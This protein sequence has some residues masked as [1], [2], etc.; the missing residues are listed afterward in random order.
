VYA[1]TLGGR[2]VVAKRRT[3]GAEVEHEAGILQLLD[4]KHV[5]HVPQ[6][7]G[8]VAGFLVLQPQ[9]RPLIF[10]LPEKI[11]LNVL[12]D[13]SEALVRAAESGVIHRDVSL[14]NIIVHECRG[15]LIDW[16]AACV[17]SAAKENVPPYGTIAYASRR[18]IRAIADG[19]GRFIGDVWVR[20]RQS[21][22]AFYV[23]TPCLAGRP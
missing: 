20:A 22:C 16:H 21:I 6:L 10:S 1:A 13:A 19:D 2:S 23:L 15:V 8:R 11:I 3:D 5:P 14:G 7:V 18:R 4:S 9:G 17:K 12:A